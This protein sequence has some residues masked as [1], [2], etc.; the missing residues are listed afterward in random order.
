MSIIIFI[1]LLLVPLTLIYWAS[2]SRTM[3]TGQRIKH[4]R[5]VVR[6]ICGVLAVA[7]LAAI[8]FGTYRTAR[9]ADALINQPTPTLWVPT[10]PLGKLELDEKGIPKNAKILFDLVL[11]RD[12]IPPRYHIES[13]VLEGP[14][15][16]R[17]IRKKLN[18]MGSE[19]DLDLLVSGV[20]VSAS[21]DPRLMGMFDLKIRG[22]LNSMSQLNHQLYFGSRYAAMIRFG[23]QNPPLSIT[24]GNYIGGMQVW[25][26]CRLAA[27]DDPLKQESVRKVL[28]ES[29]SLGMKVST[30]PSARADRSGT[31]SPG[32]LLM[33]QIG[34]SSLVLFAAVILGSQL[35]RYRSLGLAAMMLLVVLYV[36]ALDRMVV[37]IHASHLQDVKASME[38][39]LL[40][41]QLITDSFFYRKTAAAEVA[42][43][44]I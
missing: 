42:K 34:L 13:F 30:L 36:A 12:G 20:K 19:V 28:D 5:P 24:R 27:L 29:N 39:R 37:S 18:E 17:A 6:K 33:E 43:V 16:S 8:L 10:K 31:V 32:L 25:Y 21:T 44:G 23:L 2:R 22:P 15:H 38:E 11:I 26:A 7:L 35:F 4:R 1:F 9:G 3:P 41:K 14:Q 40:A